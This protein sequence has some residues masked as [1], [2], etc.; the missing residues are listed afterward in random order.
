MERKKE[1]PLGIDAISKFINPVPLFAH[2]WKEQRQG[3]ECSSRSIPLCT[4]ALIR[5]YVRRIVQGC[6]S[7]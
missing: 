6:I 5:T 3:I 2:T 4:I 1:D 7:R